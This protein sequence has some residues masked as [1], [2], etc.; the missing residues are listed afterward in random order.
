M[1]NESS[2][3]ASARG[4]AAASAASAPPP[5]AR[6]PERDVFDMKVVLRGA[7]RTGKSALSMRLQG[8][9]PFAPPPAGAAGAYVPTPEIATAFIRWAYK[10][11]DDKIKVR[12]FEAAAAAARRSCW[13]MGA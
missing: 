2:R 4:A 12:R 13:R 10:S 8:G 11:S 6:K 5:S 9:N 1:G 7:R 3:G